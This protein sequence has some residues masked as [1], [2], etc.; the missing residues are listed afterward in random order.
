MIK[1]TVVPPLPTRSDN[2]PDGPLPSIRELELNDD[3]SPAFDTEK[4]GCPDCGDLDAMGGDRC[5]ECESAFAPGEAVL[6]YRTVGF[7]KL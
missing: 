2:P 6:E 1:Q 4:P 5:G 7:R 3:G